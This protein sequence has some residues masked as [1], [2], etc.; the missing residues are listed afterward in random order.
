MSIV[1][2]HHNMFTYLFRNLWTAT[3][4]IPDGVE[5][6]Y[7]YCVCIFVTPDDHESAKPV[8]RRWETSLNPR[9][10]TCHGKR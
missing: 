9:K 10:I 8:V 1:T 2:F 3:V 7:R 6:S 4:S 5:V